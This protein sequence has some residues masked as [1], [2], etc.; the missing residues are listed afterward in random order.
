VILFCAATGISHVA[1]GITSH[2][3]QSMAARGLIIHNRHT[4]YMLTDSGR[5]TL[6]A[7]LE[8]AGLP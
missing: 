7:I 6:P 8:N 5:A 2:A 1:I 3:M 4:G